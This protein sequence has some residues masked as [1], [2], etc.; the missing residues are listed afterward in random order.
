MTNETEEQILKE[1]K[2]VNEKLEVLTEENRGLSTTVKIISL[3][4]GIAIIGPLIVYIFGF[5]INIITIG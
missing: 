3:I 4:V 1:L 2:K 5:L